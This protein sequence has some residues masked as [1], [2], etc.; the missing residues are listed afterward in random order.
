MGAGDGH[1]ACLF[2]RYG[3]MT[4]QVML[5][6][7]PPAPKLKRNKMDRSFEDLLPPFV[8]KR[9]LFHVPLL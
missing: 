4:W 2:G 8:V 1:V 3:V 6:T 5:F 9:L 7:T